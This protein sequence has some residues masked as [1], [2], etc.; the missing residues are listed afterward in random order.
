MGFISHAGGAYE[1]EDLRQFQFPNLSSFPHDVDVPKDP[2]YIIQRHRLCPY[3]T[4]LGHPK[5]GLYDMCVVQAQR[6]PYRTVKKKNLLVVLDIYRTDIEKFKKEVEK[7]KKEVEE[8]KIEKKVTLDMRSDENKGEAMSIDEAEG[9]EDMHFGKDEGEEE[10]EVKEPQVY[11]SKPLRNST[12]IKTV[13][14][15]IDFDFFTYV[16]GTMYAFSI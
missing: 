10:D 6:Y 3:I 4:V 13:K 2:A 12:T 14:L 7:L 16:S 15:L 11:T 1:I 5:D 8:Y 9:E